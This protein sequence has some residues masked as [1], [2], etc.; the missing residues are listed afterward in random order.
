MPVAGVEGKQFPETKITENGQ[1]SPVCLLRGS[2]PLREKLRMGSDSRKE[3][4]PPRVDSNNGD[5]S[6]DGVKPRGDDGRER[7]QFPDRFDS[8]KG[9]DSIDGDPPD[10]RTLP[11][12]TIAGRDSGPG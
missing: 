8:L 7:K 5:S 4:F 3:D 9:I 11:V 1:I 10:G 2:A 6:R 12:R